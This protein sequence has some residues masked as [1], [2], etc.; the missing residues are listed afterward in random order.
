[1]KLTTSSSAVNA[2]GSAVNNNLIDVIDALLGVGVPASTSVD[3]TETVAILQNGTVS[4]IAMSNLKS[5][6]S[7]RVAPTTSG[8]V[9][10]APTTQTQ[11]I[12]PA[13]TLAALT[14]TT[15]TPPSTLQAT[16]TAVLRVVFTQVVTTLTWAAG[17]GTTN[18]G[19]A[20]VAA[21]AV[22]DCVTFVWDATSSKW[23]HVS[24]A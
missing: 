8:S 1:M 14:V 21:A 7:V 5:Q 10:I 20:L 3:G 6:T 13:G 11:I 2:Q 22:G 18:A 4:N 19:V 24:S 23:F 17:A 15:P 16:Q 12:D 9:V